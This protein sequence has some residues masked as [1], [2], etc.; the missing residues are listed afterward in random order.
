M[1]LAF[2]CV[3]VMEYFHLYVCRQHYLQCPQG[4]LGKHF[5]KLIQCDPRL[6]FLSKQ[7]EIVLDFP[8]FGDT[9]SVLEDPDE[10]KSHDF[11]LK[12]EEDSSFSGLQDAPSRGQLS[13]SKI[14]PQDPVG[15]TTEIFFQNT[16]SPSSGKIMNLE[17]RFIVNIMMVSPLIILLFLPWNLGKICDDESCCIMLFL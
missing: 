16:L 12:R 6:N 2:E 7:P 14:D 1:N 10:S 15:G 8:Y 11:G 13:S 17:Y 3:K 9:D 5:E 4:L